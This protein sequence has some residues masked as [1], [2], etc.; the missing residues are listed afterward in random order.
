MRAARE[1]AL[2][3][4]LI[5]T[6]VCV[7]RGFGALVFGCLLTPE[8]GMTGPDGAGSSR[9]SFSCGKDT[10]AELLSP[11]KQRAT[12]TH[13]LSWTGVAWVSSAQGSGDCKRGQA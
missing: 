12:P 1:E 10:L 6:W 8:W 3:T 5:P 4:G 9:G 2:R 11:L 7:L 13:L